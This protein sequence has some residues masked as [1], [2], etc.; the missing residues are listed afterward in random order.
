MKTINKCSIVNFSNVKASTGKQKTHSNHNVGWFSPRYHVATTLVRV[1][2]TGG[3]YSSGASNLCRKLESAPIFGTGSWHVNLVLFCFD[4]G[5]VP[6]PCLVSK[7]MSSIK[8]FDLLPQLHA[9]EFAL[10][11]QHEESYDSEIPITE[12]FNYFWSTSRKRLRSLPTD[13]WKNI[14]TPQIA[15]P[16]GLKS[17]SIKLEQGDD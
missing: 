16:N 15:S 2:I 9:V 8:C 11:P 4:G 5:Q 13:S 10:H 3:W 14:G 17:K 6:Q 7:F 12:D 1:E